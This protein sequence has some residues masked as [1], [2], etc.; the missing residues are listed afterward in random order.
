MPGHHFQI[1][2]QY[3][4][5]SLPA[6]RRDSLGYTA[7]VEGWG[8]YASFLAGEMGM[9]EDPYDLCGRLLFDAFLTSR[10]VVDTGM[11]LL[12]WPRARAM[13]YMRENTI[14]SETEIETETLR[15]SSDLPAQAL[16]YK[17]GMRKFVE[18]REKAKNALGASFDMRRY[19]DML[20]ASGAV[21]MD[22]AE[23][24][25]DWF[26][27]E[28]KARRPP[29]P[30]TTGPAPCA[31]AS[32]GERPGFPRP[33]GGPGLSPPAPPPQRTAGGERRRG[34]PSPP[35]PSS[36]PPPPHRSSPPRRADRHRG[37]CFSREGPE[38]RTGPPEGLGFPGRGGGG[39]GAPEGRGPRRLRGFS[40]PGGGAPAARRL[41]PRTRRSGRRCTPIATRPAC[42]SISPTTRRSPSSGRSS[43]TRR[44]RGPFCGFP[45]CTGRE[46]GSTDSVRSLRRIADGRAEILLGRAQAGWR[47]TH[48]YVDD[49]ADAVVLG[50]VRERAKGRVYNVGE[51][52]TPTMGERAEAFGR[53]LGWAGRVVAVP[54]DRLPGH[55]AATGN[56]SQDVAYDTARIRRELDWVEGTDPTEALRRT[57]AWESVRRRSAPSRGGVRG[58]AARGR[59]R[60]GAGFS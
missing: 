10:L 46:T 34:G 11:N 21:P 1:N 7:F 44:S 42:P 50:V 54:D 9:Y 58:G 59:R 2:L 30:P 60:E 14:Q 29:P 53:A 52:S 35:P 43:P 48:G 37:G 8:E 55:L 56:F 57:A 26:I 32:S 27:A 16:A 20:L 23:R 31:S 39:R 45:R 12:G 18:L 19:H 3:E 28:E 22:L 5:E 24:K 47:W 33:P 6:F 49:V 15:Y 17:M 13:E 38:R 4:N 51:A 41:S 25:V 36:P 40:G